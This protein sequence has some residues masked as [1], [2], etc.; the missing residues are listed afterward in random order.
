MNWAS[1]ETLV[2]GR[3]IGHN[4]G[5]KTGKSMQFLRVQVVDVW[6]DGTFAL[7]GMAEHVS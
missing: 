3:I 5:L 4:P 2:P 7:G 6:C 1:I